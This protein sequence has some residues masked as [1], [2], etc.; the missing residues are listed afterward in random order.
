[1]GLNFF[2]DPFLKLISKNLEK[3]VE[4]IPKRNIV[5]NQ[6][7]TFCEYIKSPIPIHMLT[8]IVITFSFM[9]LE[10]ILITCYPPGHNDTNLGRNHIISLNSVILFDLINDRYAYL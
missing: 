6:A 2:L 7:A 3:T 9:L 4:G 10:A 8:S 1:M 5:G